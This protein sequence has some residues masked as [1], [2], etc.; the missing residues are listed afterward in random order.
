MFTPEEKDLHERIANLRSK[1]DHGV[2]GGHSF[3]TYFLKGHHE[4]SITLLE[5]DKN[6]DEDH[7]TTGAYL[8][9][10]A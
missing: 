5:S 6:V 2:S 4:K 3:K 1:V 9:D 7:A 8:K 10:E